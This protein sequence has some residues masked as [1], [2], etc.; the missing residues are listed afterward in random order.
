MCYIHINSD[1][2]YYY[3]YTLI[4]A[5]SYVKGFHSRNVCLIAYMF[6]F[7][8]QH[9]LMLSLVKLAKFHRQKKNNNQLS[10]GNGVAMYKAQYTQ[11]SLSNQ[12]DFCEYVQLI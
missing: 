3:S 2:H 4:D 5:V 1:L 11:K 10:T 6:F 12:A 8:N 7:L 9:A